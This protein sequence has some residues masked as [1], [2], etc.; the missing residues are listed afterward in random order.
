M[1]EIIIT[2]FCSSLLFANVNVEKLRMEPDESGF[3]GSFELDLEYNSGNVEFTSLGLEPNIA[4]CRGRHTIFWVN[5]IG[6]MWQEE[7]D[8]TNKGYS[9]LR[10]DFEINGPFIW[11]VF[12]QAE[13]NHMRDIKRRYLA[14]TGGRIIAVRREKLTIALG[15]TGM[16]E[17]EELDGD[18]SSEILRG[19][20]YINF[21]LIIREGVTFTN[22]FYYQPSMEELEDYRINDE[23]ELSI[24]LFGD[25]SFTTEL[26]YFYDSRPPK[27]IVDYDFSVENGLSYSF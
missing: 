7:E 23:A 25:L 22:T 14:G 27:G 15:L 12:A 18:I 21:H 11:E 1:R 13:F 19:S 3:G 17:Y 4:W 26:V 2:L 8:I 6:R 24:E 5:D 16:Y 10:Y 20:S 9:H